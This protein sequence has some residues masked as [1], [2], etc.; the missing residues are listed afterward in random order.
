MR[1]PQ[2]YTALRRPDTYP[3]RYSD[4]LR[5]MGEDTRPRRV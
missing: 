3:V 2:R 4:R 5:K 1:L